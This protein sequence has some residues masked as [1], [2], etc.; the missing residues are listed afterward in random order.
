MSPTPHY[1]SR[2]FKTV[3]SQV[4]HIKDSTQLRWR[5]LK[6]AAIWGA[7]A[8]LYPL[9]TI[10]QAARWG[11]QVLQQAATTGTQALLSFARS[12][13]PAPTDQPIQNVLDAIDCLEL[14]MA[15]NV[16]S[17]P[18]Q[19]SI[20]PIAKP[21]SVLAVWR[22]KLSNLWQPWR[23][24]QPPATISDLSL[25]ASVAMQPSGQS[26][27]VSQSIA[28]R[29]V[30]SLLV[31]Q[32]LVLVTADNQIL[33]VLTVDQQRQLH[34][35]IIW[36]IAQACYSRRQLGRARR[37]IPAWKTWQALPIKP[38]PQ[39]SF[40]IRA[41]YHLMAWVQQQSIAQAPLLLPASHPA[42]T[43]HPML[44]S[45][46][47]WCAT[48]LPPSLYSSPLGKGVLRGVVQGIGI[49]HFVQP[50]FLS[51]NAQKA[52]LCLTGQLPARPVLSAIAQK[53]RGYRT[54]LVAVA[55]AIALLP[56]TLALPEPA[57]AAMVPTLPAPLPSPLMVEQ[58]I[59][60][61]RLRRRWQAEAK[62][63]EQSGS[64]S[65][66]KVRLAP[67]KT[68]ARLSAQGFEGAISDWANRFS[69]T[70]KAADP[71]TIEVNAVFMGYES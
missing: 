64:P 34:Q 26:N 47:Q 4:R 57:K 62:I 11:G 63:A 30:A 2:L 36:E 21:K 20:R 53:L 25:C 45:L 28:I 3:R 19:L 9:Y 38:R 23:K 70:T 16:I 7:Q 37:A 52:P 55:G 24:A 39:Y 29:G 1:Q 18:L 56:F 66:G 43:P 6:V 40:P 33:D 14:P 12:E 54:V 60:P 67:Q 51:Q 15:G 8:A 41:I 65:Q 71:S 27:V 50:L 5:Q 59:D 58:L 44:A 31:Q 22:K 32:R 13:K 49:T 17:N 10:F 35:R 46:R 48:L 42:L 61:D 68:A 69:Q